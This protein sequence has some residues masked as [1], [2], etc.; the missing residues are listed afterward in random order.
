MGV[1][2]VA[3]CSGEGPEW[4]GERASEGSRF[5]A[6]ADGWNC[7]TEGTSWHGVGIVADRW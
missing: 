2:L 7:Y 3:E 5:L 6:G 4:L 1:R